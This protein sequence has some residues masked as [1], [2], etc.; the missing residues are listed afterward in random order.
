MR[1]GGAKPIKK[2]WEATAFVLLSKFSACLSAPPLFAKAPVPVES[3]FNAWALFFG[4]LVAL[5]CGTLVFMVPK[6]LAAK[7][8]IKVAE[9]ACDDAERHR[10]LL[11]AARF[12]HTGSPLRQAVDKAK[13]QFS[14]DIVWSTSKSTLAQTV[15]DFKAAHGGQDPRTLPLNKFLDWIPVKVMSRG[16]GFAADDPRIWRL[17][18]A[19]HS[20]R[21]FTA[22]KNK[23]ST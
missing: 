16:D 20:R 14:A 21:S 23:S 17:R 5:Y 11:A 8:E 6:I 15:S 1:G 22:C 4:F 18:T 7:K 13:A 19:V 12:Y 9:K 2:H 10:H 3:P